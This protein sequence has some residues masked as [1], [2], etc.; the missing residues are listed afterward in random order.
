MPMAEKDNKL[1]MQFGV[2]PFLKDLIVFDTLNTCLNRW[3]TSE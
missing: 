3:M 2:I 1:P